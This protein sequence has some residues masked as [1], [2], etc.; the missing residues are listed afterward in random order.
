MGE[1][2]GIFLD[3]LIGF[4][5]LILLAALCNVFAFLNTRNKTNRVYYHFNARTSW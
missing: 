1:V 3:N 5:G 4:D 2:A